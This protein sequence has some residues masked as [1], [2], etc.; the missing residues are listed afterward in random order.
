MR[1]FFILSALLLTFVSGAQDKYAFIKYELSKISFSND[2]S[3][4]MKF[5]QKLDSFAQKKKKVIRVA[6]IGGSHV[7]GGTWSNTF[8]GDLQT[9]LKPTGGGYFVF[10][11][12]IAK[13]NSPHF[14]SSFTNGNWK[15]CRSVGKEFCLPLGMSAMSITTNDSSNTFGMILTKRSLFNGFNTIRVYHNFNPSFEFQI[16]PGKNLQFVRLDKKEEG[17][18]QFDIEATTDSI[19]FDLLKID[20]M[21]KDFILYGFSVESNHVNSLH[22]ATLGANGAS[23]GSFLRCN[24]FSDQ[25]RTIPPDLVIISLGVNDTQAKDFKTEEYI[26]NYDSLIWKLKAINPDVAIL[27][28]TTT[29]NFIR[30]KTANKR[31]V[32]AQEAMFELMNKHNVAVWDLYAVMGGYKSMLNWVKAGLAA[33]DRVHFSPKGYSILGNLMSEALLRSYHY[34]IKNKKP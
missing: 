18:T 27:L 20:S 14:A 11:Y 34:N 13:T 24:Y 7:Q 23:S 21:N 19:S 5:Y 29:D 4:Y 30:R 16:S 33:K 2:S 15:K 1:S 25:L 10:P 22:L 32:Q 9:E 31:P 17:Y 28:T 26:E 6:H 3:S 12:R 8:L